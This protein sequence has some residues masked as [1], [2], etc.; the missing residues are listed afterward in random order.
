MEQSCAYICVSESV[1]VCV[2]I[3]LL[4]TEYQNTNWTN[5]VKT[6]LKSEDVF[7][8]PHIFKGLFEGKNWL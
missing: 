7:A 2:Y 1:C 6:I 8:G 5:K 4:H 3:R